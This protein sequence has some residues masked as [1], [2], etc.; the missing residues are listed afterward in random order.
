MKDLKKRL[1]VKECKML[2][3]K[4]AKFHACTAVLYEKVCNKIPY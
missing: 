1:N 4:V 3:E 2:L